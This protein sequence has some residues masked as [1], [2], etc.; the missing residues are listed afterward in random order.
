MC[1]PLPNTEIETFEYVSERIIN[2]RLY[3]VEMDNRAPQ[4]VTACKSVD[5]PLSISPNLAKPSSTLSLP[6]SPLPRAR[7]FT[8][9]SQADFMFPTLPAPSQSR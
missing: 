6:D 2:Y 7:L 9:P 8:I 1:F 4:N 5:L 3:C